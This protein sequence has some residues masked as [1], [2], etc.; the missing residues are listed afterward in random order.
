M[1][2]HKTIT[3]WQ[4]EAPYGRSLSKLLKKI[5]NKQSVRKQFKEWKDK[6]RVAKI[7]KTLSKTKLKNMLIWDGYAYVPTECVMH[8][9][10]VTYKK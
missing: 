7:L 9:L 8:V 5:P 6:H 10:Y 3:F 4:I 2:K 1:K